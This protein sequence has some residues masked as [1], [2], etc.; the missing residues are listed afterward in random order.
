M[1]ES[2][3][4]SRKRFCEPVRTQH[5]K[6]V[7]GFT[8]GA[9]YEHMDWEQVTTVAWSTDK[10]LVC[11]AHKHEARLIAAAPLSNITQLGTSSTARK[12]WITS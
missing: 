9:T 10:P 4:A 12:A 5:A 1:L 7:F 3:R 8:A 2:W 11:L 6:E